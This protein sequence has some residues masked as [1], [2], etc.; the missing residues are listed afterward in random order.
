M[1]VVAEPDYEYIIAEAIITDCIA[2]L[3]DKEVFRTYRL[4]F[5]DVDMDPDFTREENLYFTREAAQAAI[6][7]IEGTANDSDDA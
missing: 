5:V 7:Q 3:D 6:D 2:T 4:D 1:G